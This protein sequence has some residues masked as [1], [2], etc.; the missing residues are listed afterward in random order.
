MG[1]ARKLHGQAGFTIA[2]V[3]VAGFILVIALIPIT[4]MFD[5][6]FKGIRQ[7][8]QTQQSISCATH[9]M[10]EIQ[11][12]PFYTAR[13]PD[14]SASHAGDID[15]HFWGARSPIYANPTPGESIPS[16]DAIPEVP[17]Y[18]YGELEGYEKYR[19]G[20]QVSY[21]DDGL[22][23]AG[24][25]SEWDPRLSGFDRPKNAEG[26]TLHMI[27]VRATVYWGDA[28]QE[29]SYY[30]ENIITDTL[31]IYNFGA[32]KIIVDPPP[33][34]PVELTNPDKPN[35]AVHW[36]NPNRLIHVTI[37]GW[38]FD[39][40]TISASLVRHKNNDIPI[41]ITSVTDTEVKGT[42]DLYTT[43]TVLAD[44]PD[45][46]PK[47]A[48]G[49]WSLKIN[50]EDLFSTYLYNGF[51]VEYPAPVISDFGNATDMGKI[52]V[53][54]QTAVQMKIEGAP[55]I[56]RIENPAARLLRFDENGLLLTQINGTVTST[57]VPA[58]TEGYTLDLCTIFATFDLSFAPAGEYYMHV[59]NTKEPT[60]IGHRA[61]YSAVP[62]II[63][64][65]K[66][67]VTGITVDK[68]GGTNV[69]QNKGN[70][71]AVT[72]TGDR[73]NQVGT[74][75]VEIYLCS[76]VTD[77]L[78]AGSW[79][80]GVVTSVPN[81]NTIKGTFDATTLPLGNYIVYVRNLINNV[82]GWTVDA[83]LSVTFLNK[84][85]D[86]FVPNTGYAFYEN[87]YDIPSTVNGLGLTNTTAVTITNG[88]VEYP[89]EYSISSNTTLAVNL[90]LI[91]CSNGAWTLRVKLIGEDYLT[92]LF[93][94]TLG[95]AKILP[96]DDTK[97]A[98]KIWRAG[99]GFIGGGWSVETT[100]AWAE[101][102]AS[103]ATNTATAKFEILGMGFPV[104]GNTT[105]RGWLAGSP[106]SFVAIQ[107][108]TTMDR[109]N[110]VVK[111]IT[112]PMNMPIAAGDCGIAVQRVGDTVWDWY[113][114]RWRLVTP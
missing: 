92:T 33:T 63:E 42:I 16:W 85:L 46:A 23:V 21:L 64:D 110:K 5:T 53:N 4:A 30:Q 52:G 67:V 57:T 55:F 112:P 98:I 108:P 25:S 38:G 1:L 89:I 69:Y 83:P 68:T 73:F 111:L 20:V 93:T 35:A 82:A 104:S 29:K 40:T 37:A 50:Q 84:Y 58:G 94:V 27:L 14:L 19:V 79:V 109:T 99:I 54:N 103:T 47:A 13:T 28:G 78:P 26:D 15:D 114:R 65:F 3:M 24:M 39:A 18:G 31:A 10:E 113:D 95:P 62:Y 12:I 90:N 106:G 61:G 7:F 49:Y 86:N 34:N 101:A 9:V 44:D 70:P 48:V 8:E 66:P 72:I 81:A 71:W 100:A 36:S 107:C 17:F 60:L 59:V 41:N 88:S 32:T 105:I 80:Q 102:Y 43:G 96:P 77:G 6:S 2:E 45:W 76:Q 75:P 87:Y 97:H 22:G 56:T 74:P 11:A 91:N 51:V